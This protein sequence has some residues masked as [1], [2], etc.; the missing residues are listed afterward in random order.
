MAGL[1]NPPSHLLPDN[2]SL[3]FDGRV[4]IF[5]SSKVLEMTSKLCICHYANT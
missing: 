1:G 3:P 5:A 2:L 4:H